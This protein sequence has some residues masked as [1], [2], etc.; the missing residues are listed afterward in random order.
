MTKPKTVKPKRQWVM[1]ALIWQNGHVVRVTNSRIEAW[2]NLIYEKNG[3]KRLKD[4]GVE[5]KKVLVTEV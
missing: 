4:A 3:V 2:G 5:V 1:W